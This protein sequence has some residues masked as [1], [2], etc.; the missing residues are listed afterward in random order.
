[1][2]LRGVSVLLVEDDVDNL[3]LLSSCL[4]GEGA[5]THGAGSIAAAL[6]MV[7]GKHI[8]VVVSDLE[9]PD[10]DGCALLRQLALAEARGPRPAVAIT[11]YS[12]QAWRSRAS[13][14][15]FSRYAVKPFSIDQLIAWIFELSRASDGAGEN[16]ES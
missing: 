14:C 15:G 7:I 8:D 13:S 9:L 4:E 16:V 12:Q 2:R 5:T 3:E 6:A 1:M 11:G 10:G